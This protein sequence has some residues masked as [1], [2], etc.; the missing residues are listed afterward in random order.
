MPT[1]VLNSLAETSSNNVGAIVELRLFE[2]VFASGGSDRGVVV[3]FFRTVAAGRCGAVKIWT[4]IQWA[5]NTRTSLL[6]QNV[7]ARVAIS[8]LIHC[9]HI[10]CQVNSA[11][12]A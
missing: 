7:L 6:A 10:L 3:G 1:R 9:C 4:S 5:R 8:A 11:A 12:S 2:S